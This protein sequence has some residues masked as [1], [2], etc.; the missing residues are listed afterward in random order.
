VG[1]V[2]TRAK[3][4]QLCV[5]RMDGELMVILG[6]KVDKGAPFAA[7][8]V[9][10]LMRIRA[11]ANRIMVLVRGFRKGTQVVLQETCV[12]QTLDD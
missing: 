5:L 2:S 7:C 1:K 4:K 8:V 10:F 12:P 11:V 3:Q 6:V 9:L